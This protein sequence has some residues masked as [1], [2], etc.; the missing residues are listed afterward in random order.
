[1]GEAAM[2]MPEPDGRLE[3]WERWEQPAIA[4]L[5]Y[6][7]LAITTIVGAFIYTG[8]EGA[9]LID[10]GLVGLAAGLLVTFTLWRSVRERP[11]FMAVYFTALVTVMALLVIRTPW[12]GFFTFTGYFYA[13]YLP[14]GWP[15][16]LGVGAVALVTGTSQNGGLPQ[17]T[18]GAIAFW[19]VI[20]CINLLVAEALTWFGWVS[21]QQN[22]RRKLLVTELSEANR[23]LIASLEENAGLHAQLLAQAREAGMLD[24]RQRMAREIHDTLAQ[25]LTGII[26]QLEAAGQAGTSAEQWRHHF[27]SAIRLARESLS[28]ARRSV[29][30]LQPE[31]LEMARLPDALVEVAERWSARSGV[32]A[33]V[34]TTGS[35]RPMRPEIEVALLRTA[36]EALANVAKHARASRVGLTLSYMDDEVALDIRDDGVGFEPPGQGGGVNGVTPGQERAVGGQNPVTGEGGRGPDHAG[37][38]LRSGGLGRQHGDGFGLTAMRQRVEGLAGTL[39]IESEIGTGT[40]VSA[41]VPAI[42]AGAG[43]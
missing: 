29:Q 39:E 15:R 40:A 18:A 9:L 13:Y 25:G 31:P 7:M 5:P 14:L 33:Q 16:L 11:A 23:K 3:A 38:R 20:V 28:E 27:D 12:F 37:R 19:V 41:S 6:V 10:L 26:T 4:A 34:T 43:A 22:D 1:M 24:E 35:A 8:S 2:N 36:Q 17:D 21:S 32:A 30:A 42:P